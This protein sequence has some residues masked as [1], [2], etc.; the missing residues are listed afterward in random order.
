[1]ILS[2]DSHGA[3]STRSVSPTDRTSTTGQQGQEDTPALVLL[4]P[5]TCLQAPCEPT[6]AAAE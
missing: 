6:T 2:N 3:G 4:I 1:M 5:E